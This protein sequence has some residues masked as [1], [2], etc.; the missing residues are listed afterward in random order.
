MKYLPTN[1]PRPEVIP[2]HRLSKLGP[3]FGCTCG[4][5]YPA[6][7]SKHHAESSQKL[8]EQLLR[9]HDRT[10]REATAPWLH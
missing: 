5:T 7:Q 10:N 6:A 1:E 9:E 4:A 2:F 8:H 3:V